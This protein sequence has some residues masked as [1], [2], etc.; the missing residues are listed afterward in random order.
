MLDGVKGGHDGEL[1]VTSQMW[2]ETRLTADTGR[3]GRGTIFLSR[4]C[5]PGIKG[6]V[7]ASR[8]VVSN[9]IVTFLI[10]LS[11]ARESLN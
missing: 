10:L 8:L 6:L 3:F 11:S 7:S 9:G 1:H 5:F 4:R 2:K